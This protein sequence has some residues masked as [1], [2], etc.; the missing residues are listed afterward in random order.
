MANEGTKTGNKTATG[1]DQ[2]TFGQGV[3][4]QRAAG[5]KGAAISASRS[6]EARSEAGKKAAATRAEKYGHQAPS[7]DNMTGA[8]TTVN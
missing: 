2:E 4:A 5:E 1:A 6:P 7:A 8:K 3:D